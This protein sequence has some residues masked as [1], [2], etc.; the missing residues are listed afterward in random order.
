MSHII[1]GTILEYKSDGD[2]LSLLIKGAGKVEITYYYKNLQDKINF[3]QNLKLG[4]KVEIRGEIKYP[5][6]N[7]IPNTFNYQEYLYNNKIYTIFNASDIKLLNNKISILFQLKNSFRK[8]VA[9]F[10]NVKDYM[11]AFILG[12]KSYIDTNI[13]SSFKD[14]GTT[15]LFAVSGMHVSFLVLAL[16][17]ILSKMKIK[18]QK[19]NIICILFLIFY[20][21]LIGFSASVV[22]ASMLTILLLINKKINLNL[23]SLNILYILFLFLIIINPFYIYDLGFIYSFTTSFGLML[24]SKKITGNYLKKLFLVSFIA[25]ICSLPIT[26]SN[27]YEFNILTII[28]NIIIVPLVSLILFPLTIVVFLLPFLEPILFLGFQILEQLSLILSSLSINIVVPKIHFIF[29]VLYY[30]I[31]YLIYKYNYKFT[32]VLILLIFGYKLTPLLDSNAY[33]YFIDVGQG[34]STL[35][36]SK[37]RHDVILVDTGGT[38]EY[39]KET[40]QIRNKTFSLGIN[41]ITFL[42]SLGIDTIDL[43]ICTHG[44]FDHLGYGKDI[45]NEIKIK[46]IMLNNNVLNNQEQNLLNNI[47]ILKKDKYETSNLKIYNLN[48]R[49]EDDENNSSLVLYTILNNNNFLLMGDAPK[50]IEQ[51]ILTKYQLPNIDVL[52]VGHHGSKTS[53]SKNFITT[54][55]PK[56]AIFSVGKNNRYGHPH[57]EVLDNFKN[58]KIYRTDF[59]GTIAF[60]IKNN[61]L[62]IKTWAP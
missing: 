57:Q 47:K 32:I 43:L 53:S 51:N 18:E 55:N 39:E 48:D 52:K 16:K 33:A 27:F 41:I 37:N 59:D 5:S 31:I 4:L 2:K 25:F 23:P 44:D 21:F 22:R 60:K 30:L 9:K 7:T 62:E 38:I 24:F 35:L 42:K 49:V 50:E 46:S 20:M 26:L 58:L 1:I 13:Y 11:Y 8:K 19:I 14:C 34:D 40:W 3:E 6:S 36:L 45:L 56:Y 10:K 15:H 29:Y 28:N 54:T 17:T 61:K 12:D